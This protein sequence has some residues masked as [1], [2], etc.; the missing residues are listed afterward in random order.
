MGYFLKNTEQCL[1]Q[2]L[3]ILAAIKIKG[4]FSEESGFPI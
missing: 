1:E 2:F 3:Q 4:N